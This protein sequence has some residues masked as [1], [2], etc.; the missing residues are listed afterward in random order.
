MLV[1]RPDRVA[2]GVVAAAVLDGQ[3]VLGVGGV[4]EQGLV[5]AGE[6]QRVLAPGDGGPRAAEHGAGDAEVGAR[7]DH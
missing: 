3:V 1:L 6:P 5:V 4:V 2:A 7:R